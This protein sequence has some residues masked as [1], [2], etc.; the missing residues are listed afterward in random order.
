MSNEMPIVE[1]ELTRRKR[2]FLGV[3]LGRALLPAVPDGVHLYESVQRPDGSR[4]LRRIVAS[5]DENPVVSPQ[6]SC[7]YRVGL[8]G[9]YFAPTFS[10]VLADEQGHEWDCQLVGQLTV[11]DSRRVLTSLGVSMAGP[12]SPVTRAIAESWIAN[13]IASRVRDSAREYS[14][15]DL[16]DREALPPT[17]WEKHVNGWLDDCGVAVRIDMVSWSSA[18]AGAAKAEAARLQDLERV[19]CARRREQE[20]EIREARAKAE[21]EEAKKQLEAD[22]ALSEKERAHQ[23]QLLEKRHR[24]VLIEADSDIERAKREAEKAALEHEVTLAGLRH[25]ADALIHAEERA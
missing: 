2:R 22:M 4:D 18:K 11:A 8:Y 14:I 12:Q 1:M 16:V 10:Q 24:K 13:R 20:A 23:L 3:P 7:L 6:A 21:Y 19:A 9:C 5:G 15:A 17:W 25:D